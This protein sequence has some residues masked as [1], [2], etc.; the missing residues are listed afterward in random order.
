MDVLYL[1]AW[2]GNKQ[3]LFRKKRCENLVEDPC[4]FIGKPVGYDL[5]MHCMIFCM[6]GG[7]G[8]IG[9]VRC[10]E[11]CVLHYSYTQSPRDI[12]ELYVSMVTASQV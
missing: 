11:N 3:A 9:G 2:L 5:P 8:V 1:Q 7:K 4:G 12:F 10:P 6:S